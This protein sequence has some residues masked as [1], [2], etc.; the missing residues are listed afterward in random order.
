MLDGAK[1]P[2]VTPTGASAVP[3]SASTTTRA[4]VGR[5][6][7]RRWVAAERLRQQRHRAGAFSRSPE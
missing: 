2:Q 6:G 5:D 3:A 7:L 4:G 1:Y